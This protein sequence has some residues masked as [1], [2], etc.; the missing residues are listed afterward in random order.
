MTDPHGHYTFRRPGDYIWPQGW[1]GITPTR[2]APGVPL[3]TRE[4]DNPFA[5]AAGGLLP[6]RPTILHKYRIVMDDGTIE[7]IRAHTVFTTGTS[8]L[9]ADVGRY[10]FR[11]DGQLILDLRAKDIASIR[12]LEEPGAD[13][14]D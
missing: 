12:R 4:D 8:V 6:P 9:S 5:F 13:D 1:R 10:Q 7:Y 3:V 14:D 2:D 11:R